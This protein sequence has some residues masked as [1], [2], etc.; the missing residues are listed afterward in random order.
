MKTSDVIRSWG[1]ILRGKYPSMSIE[2]TRECPLRCPGCYAYENDHLRSLGPLRD[3]SDYKGQELIDRLLDLV[4]NYNPLHI[5]IVGGEPLVRY[6]ELNVLLPKLIEMGIAVQLVTSA[7][8]PIPEEWAVLED[9]H[10]VVSIDGLQPDHDKRRAPAT[11]E[12]ILQ[13]VVGQLVTVHC[14]ITHQMTLRKNYLQEFVEFWSSQKE[15]KKIWMSIFTPQIGSHDEEIL[16]A[17]ERVNVLDELAAMRAVYPKLYM[18]DQVIEGYKNP[19]KSPDDCIFARTTLSVTADLKS[20]IVP[21][22]FGGNPDCSQCGCMAS[23]GL[24][25]VGDHR[26]FGF[27][28]LRS[29]FNV[30]SSI[31][32]IAAKKNGSA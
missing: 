31:G 24:K 17:E 32:S 7:V 20:K 30:S 19:P 26:L 5:S 13:N 14:T 9:L 23:A 11:Y 21:C 28:P 29:I 2:I 12:R 25:A 15:V 3:L 8:R 1:H 4:R 10:L 16:S 18:P 22:Q 27:L 6:R